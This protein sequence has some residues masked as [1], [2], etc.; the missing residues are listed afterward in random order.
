MK[1]FVI[2]VGGQL[3]YD[4]MNALKRRGCE[5]FGSDIIESADIQLDFTDKN[6]VETVRFQ[7]KMY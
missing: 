5:T 1:V 2:G 3:G 7:K 6:A 4:V